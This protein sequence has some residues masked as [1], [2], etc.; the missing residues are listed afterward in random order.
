MEVEKHQPHIRRGKRAGSRLM[1]PSSVRAQ[2]GP[3]REAAPH[4]T[5]GTRLSGRWLV[6]ARLGW[7]I[8]AAFFIAIL[9]INLPVYV[10]QLHNVGDESVPLRLTAESVQALQN[11][12]I[13]LDLYALC[14]MIL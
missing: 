1:I 2:P 8:V 9:V 10:I 5:V 7:G 12:G 3:N 11:L 14:A 4:Y 13:S 6:L